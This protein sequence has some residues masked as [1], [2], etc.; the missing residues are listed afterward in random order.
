MKIAYFLRK[1]VGIG[2]SFFIE[3][4]KLHKF[5]FSFSLNIH[6]CDTPHS[7]RN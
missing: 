1:K 7:L 5:R 6:I 2:V 3:K 4:E